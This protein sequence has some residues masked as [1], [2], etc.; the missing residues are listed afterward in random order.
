MDVLYSRNSLLQQGLVIKSKHVKS[1]WQQGWECSTQ[2]ILD[3]AQEQPVDTQMTPAGKQWSCMILI[4]VTHLTPVLGCI[5]E[6]DS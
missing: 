3:S 4:M 6:T 5:C 2:I 1:A